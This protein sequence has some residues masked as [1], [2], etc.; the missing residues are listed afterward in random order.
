MIYLGIGAVLAFTY[1]LWAMF[2]QSYNL[3]N[4]LK[5]YVSGVNQP[6]NESNEEFVKQFFIETHQGIECI[7]IGYFL[8][9]M[10]SVLTIFIWPLVVIVAPTYIISTHYRNRNIEREKII[11]TLKS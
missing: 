10:I 9:T 1:F 8:H 11:G 5:W 4:Y 3:Y 7:C 2:H 6:Y